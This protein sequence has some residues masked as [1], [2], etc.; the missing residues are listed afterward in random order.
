MNTFGGIVP[1]IRAGREVHVFDG[2]T[3]SVQLTWLHRSVTVEFHTPTI[4]RAVRRERARE[5]ARVRAVVEAHLVEARR[6]GR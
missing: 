3:Y 5:T 6:G 4:P 2:A 1:W